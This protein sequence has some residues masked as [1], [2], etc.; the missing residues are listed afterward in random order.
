MSTCV[1]LRHGRRRHETSIA[2]RIP[3]SRVHA[4]AFYDQSF[5]VPKQ[6]QG[7]GLVFQ[8]TSNWSRWSRGRAGVLGGSG[9]CVG[10]PLSHASRGSLLPTSGRSQSPNAR[11]EDRGDVLSCNGVQ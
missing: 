2:G 7:R 8:D 4:D 1:A 6:E 9:G 3:P 11:H 10:S 5:G